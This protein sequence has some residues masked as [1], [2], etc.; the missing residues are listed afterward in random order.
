MTF[1]SLTDFTIKKH[2]K[3]VLKK[4]ATFTHEDQHSKP[5]VNNFSSKCSILRNQKFG[6]FNLL[7]MKIGGVTICI[8]TLDCASYSSHSPEHGEKA[9]R[10][11]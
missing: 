9:Y 6:A 11:H 2:K 3:K 7:Y 8:P 4:Y 1:S 10:T 5:E